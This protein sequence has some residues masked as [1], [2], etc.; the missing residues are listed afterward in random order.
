MSIEDKTMPVEL[1][2]PRG[3]RT[4]ELLFADGHLGTYP[5]RLLRGFCPCAECQG[6][7]GPI[8]FVEG[9]DLELT[10]VSEVGNYAIRLTWG[11]GH[12][13][14]IY[15]FSFLRDLCGCSECATQDLESRVFGRR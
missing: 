11:D 10:E 5:H 3:A 7:E 2:A 9:G 4:M 1:R 14:G 12:R 8:R 13:T 15:S 6:H